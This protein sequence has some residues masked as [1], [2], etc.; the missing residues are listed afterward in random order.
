MTILIPQMTRS[1]FIENHHNH[2]LWDEVVRALLEFENIPYQTFSRFSLGGNIVY[3]IDDLYVLKLFA[4]FDSR[5]FTIETEVLTQTD[6][7]NVSIQ[8]PEI[9]QSGMYEGWNYFLM[10]RVPGELL[11][12]V[13]HDLTAKE[14]IGVAHD[15]G[16]LIRQMHQL[17]ISK[18][19]VL[20]N[21]FESWITLQKENVVKHHASTGLSPHLLEEVQDYVASFVPSGEKVLLTG[22]YTPFNLLMSK[23]NGQWTL[24]GLIDFAD[25]FLGEP[26]YDL[27]GPT[28][29]SFYK[30]PGLTKTFLNAYGLTL[31]E[32]TR[33][34]LM[35]LLLLH[36]FSH[37]LNYMEGEM[38][39]DEVHSLHKLSERFFPTE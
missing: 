19:R 33:L 26:E 38:D 23:V 6:W 31:D 16:L 36:R 39:M 34:R 27:L 4:P 18:Y 28:L 37:L 7:T 29:F 20:E 14:K 11:I 30:E 22:E 8:V 25:C 21:S 13:W 32:A 2:A 5:E 35:Q 15:L 17:D 12:D 9:V 10:S 3:G 24:T 1:E